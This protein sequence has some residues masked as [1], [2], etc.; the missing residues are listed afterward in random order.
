[1]NRQKGG[2]DLAIKHMPLCRSRTVEDHVR[3][4]MEGMQLVGHLP[5]CLGLHGAY[6]R[7]SPWVDLPGAQ[8]FLVMPCVL[9]VPC[10]MKNVLRHCITLRGQTT[11]SLA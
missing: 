3:H 4:E 6:A 9:S 7:P 5:G 10:H 2:V 11:T 1:M 8:Y